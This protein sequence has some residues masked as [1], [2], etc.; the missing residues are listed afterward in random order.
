MGHGLFYKQ[1]QGSCTSVILPKLNRLSKWAELK[2]FI[3]GMEWYWHSCRRL[4]LI[5]VEVTC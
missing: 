3:K 4:W 1:K 5:T 2:L